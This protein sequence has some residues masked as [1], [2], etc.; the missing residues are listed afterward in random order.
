MSYPW[1][2]NLSGINRL[3]LDCQCRALFPESWG[4]QRGFLRVIQS[5]YN[6]ISGGLLFQSIIS[7]PPSSGL[8]DQDVFPLLTLSVSLLRAPAC[9]SSS[10]HSTA[11]SGLPCPVQISAVLGLLL[12]I[13]QEGL[14]LG[15]TV[16]L[17]E[18]CVRPVGA[19]IEWPRS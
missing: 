17:F 15:A 12:V 3:A 5:S 13:S 18:D 9:L 2:Q 14:V 1:P 11:F 4:P 6:Y 19:N 16:S 10:V 7:G 8:S